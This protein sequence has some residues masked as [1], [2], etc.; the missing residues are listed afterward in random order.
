MCDSIGIYM[1]IP[2][3][4][5]ISRPSASISGC[6]NLPKASDRMSDGQ[7]HSYFNTKIQLPLEN[8]LDLILDTLMIT[9]ANISIHDFIFICINKH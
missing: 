4:L 9:M 8:H 3:L 2:I 1:N 6:T 7:A 5:H